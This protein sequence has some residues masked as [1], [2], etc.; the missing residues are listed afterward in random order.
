M[1]YFLEKNL[2]CF[3]RTSEVCI[4]H[5]Y[6]LNARV[7]S[8][9][10]ERGFARKKI[11]PYENHEGHSAHGLLPSASAR[12]FEINKERKK[13]RYAHH[14]R[15]ITPSMSFQWRSPGELSGS[16]PLG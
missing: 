1:R 9:K 10:S 4:G 15:T 12:V 7:I 2:R 13:K 5:T 16:R 8:L 11:F 6:S 14:T 3:V